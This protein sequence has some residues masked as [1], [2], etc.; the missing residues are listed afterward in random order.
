MDNVISVSDLNKTVK[1][2]LDS[3]PMLKNVLVEGEISNLRDTYRSGH[4]YFSLKDSEA[5]ISAVMFRG[6]AEKLNIK[7][8][9]G[10]KVLVKG[11]PSIYWQDGRYQL[12]V[13]AVEDAGIGDL[14]LQYEL[15][16]KKLE[17]EGLF[18]REH[19]K[20]I[21]ERPKKIVAVTSA[22]GAAIQDIKNVLS[23]RYPICE[24]EIYNVS[25]QGEKAAKE[26]KDA[27]LHIDKTSDA[28]LI[29]V[30]RGGGSYEDLFCFNDEDLARAI[31]ACHIPIISAVGHEIDFTISD[32]VAD[33]R[34]PTPTA[35][36]EL[37]VPDIKEDFLFLNN[38]KISILRNITN[39]IEKL[40]TRLMIYK[41][42]KLL[43]SPEA[44]IN[45]RQMKIDMIS[46]KLE[47]LAEK[48]LSEKKSKYSELISQFNALDPHAVMKRGYAFVKN[49]K[50]VIKSV[51]ETKQGDELNLM[52]FDGELVVSVEEKRKY[53]D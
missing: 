12:I 33:M 15:L 34:A 26:I 3:V 11:Q 21:P 7:L 28:D 51:D 39:E 43:S 31:Y 14:S 9:D 41:D 1:S 49:Q 32:F 22:S 30:G 17:K 38:S 16:K 53:N 42:H 50:K 52:M 44:F 47:N 40:R 48:I 29:I 37:A 6:Y 4:I 13:Y 19:K 10:K 36:A 20:A 24:L 23:R 25:V 27:I 46:S 2:F 8:Q 45:E 35:A 18:D 5:S